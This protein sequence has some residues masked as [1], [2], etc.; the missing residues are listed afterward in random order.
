MEEEHEAG[1]AGADTGAETTQQEKAQ[2]QVC[3]INDVMYTLGR[4]Y[5]GHT[6]LKGPPGSC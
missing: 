2:G 3:C 5:T 1:E 4:P 6:V